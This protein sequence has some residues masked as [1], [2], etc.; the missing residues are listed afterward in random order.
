MV[1]VDTEGLITFTLLGSVKGSDED[2]DDVPGGDLTP[3]GDGPG[4]DG[5]D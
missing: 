3:I 1:E 5:G 4:L 2:D